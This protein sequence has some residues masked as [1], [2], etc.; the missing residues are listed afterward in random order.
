MIPSSTI[1]FAAFARQLAGWAALLAVLCLPGLHALHL[2][3]DAIE[4]AAEVHVDM[5]SPLDGHAGAPHAPHAHDAAHCAICASVATIVAT[6]ALLAMAG[7][8]FTDLPARFA[9][10]AY[11]PPSVADAV[12][13]LLASPRSPPICA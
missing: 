1:R 10:P 6:A 2:R 8:S 3:L 9:S 4:E 5:P 11:A 12:V 13:P 7:L